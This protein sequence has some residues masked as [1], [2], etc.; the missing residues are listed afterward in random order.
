M[1]KWLTKLC[2]AMSIY[3]GAN[4]GAA[5]I[6]RF[7]GTNTPKITT[8]AH[9]AMYLEFHTDTGVNALRGFTLKYDVIIGSKY[10]LR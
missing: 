8:L 9:G 5:E 3:V 4:P 2:M 10:F 7:C 6:V 1:G